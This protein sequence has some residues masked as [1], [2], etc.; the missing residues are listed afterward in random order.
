QSSND[1]MPIGESSV[2]DPAIISPPHAAARARWVEIVFLAFLC[3]DAVLALLAHR[4]AYFGWDLSLERS[5]QAISL[6]GF[7]QTMIAVSVLGNDWI[8]WA[9]VGVVGFGLII[10]SL[11]TEGV[12][13]M[14]GVFSGWA[15]NS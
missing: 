10:A 3:I 13:C 2:A 11:R 6:P 12:T 8:G 5:I 1:S 4:Y 7:A 15:V 14:A 9:L